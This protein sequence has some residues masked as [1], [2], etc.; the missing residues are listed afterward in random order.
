M[1][2]Q[3]KDSPQYLGHFISKMMSKILL[4]L[5]KFYKSYFKKNSIFDF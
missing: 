3:Q 2:R 5:T 1:Q 4:N